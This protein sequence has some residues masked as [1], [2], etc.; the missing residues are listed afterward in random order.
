MTNGSINKA[1][2]IQ[3]IDDERRASL[4]ILASAYSQGR[5]EDPRVTSAANNVARVLK[6][7][8]TRYGSLKELELVTGI[9]AGTLRAPYIGNPEAQQVISDAF[10][11]VADIADI[12]STDFFLGSRAKDDSSKFISDYFQAVD[13]R[14]C[15]R[16]LHNELQP[17]QLILQDWYQA[18]E[19]CKLQGVDENAFIKGS[20]LFKVS[21]DCLPYIKEHQN[22][23]PGLVLIR[24]NNGPFVEQW[25]STTRI[26]QV[27][28]FATH[29]AWL[30]VLTGYTP[31]DNRAIQGLYERYNP[32]LVST[33]ISIANKR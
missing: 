2:A 7:Y 25:L 12:I 29:D 8:L 4:E 17:V 30:T 3:G 27:E 32:P 26:G 22:E 16:E 11:T 19:Y 10:V 1:L 20:N 28:G 21:P 14:P 13:F 23:F 18:V 6:K 31:T 24:L 15:A 33:A 5:S 9:I